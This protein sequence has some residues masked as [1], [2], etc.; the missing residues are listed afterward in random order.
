MA[1]RNSAVIGLELTN[2]TGPDPLEVERVHK[3]NFYE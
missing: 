3:E 2:S 1:G